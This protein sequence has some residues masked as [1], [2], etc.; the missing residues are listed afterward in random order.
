M[1]NR[2]TTISGA[3]RCLFIG[4]GSAHSHTHIY[5]YIYIYTHITHTHTK[6]HK[7]GATKRKEA[8][9]YH[10]SRYLL[11]ASLAGCWRGVYAICILLHLFIY[12][13]L[14]HYR[15]RG[16]YFWAWWRKSVSFLLLKAYFRLRICIRCSCLNYFQFSPFFGKSN[17]IY[18]TKYWKSFLYISVLS[19]FLPFISLFLVF[20]I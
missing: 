14:Y 13:I 18:S 4:A 20:A 5:I 2:R 7:V 17:F 15:V 10:Y 11:A 6:T 12:S 8:W 9:L 16:K 3:P 1:A 19:L